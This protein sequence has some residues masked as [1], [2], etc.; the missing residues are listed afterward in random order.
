MLATLHAIRY[1]PFFMAYSAA[2]EVIM[3]PTIAN[4]L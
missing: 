1:L 3:T 2:I 4:I